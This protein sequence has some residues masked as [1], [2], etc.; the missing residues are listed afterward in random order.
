MAAA[1]GIAPSRDGARRRHRARRRAGDGGD[2]S[3]GGPGVKTPTSFLY[4]QDVATGV[5]TITLNRPDRL[6]ALTFDV[7]DELGTTFRALNIESGVRAIVI[8][9]AGKAFCSGGDVRDIIG[10]LVERDDRGLLE[11]TRMTCDLILAI[12]RC[13]VPVVAALNG[14]T[15][16]AGAVMAT[17]CDVRIAAASARIAFLFTKVG[18]SGADM[19]AAWLLPRIVGRGRAAELLMSGDF[20]SAEEAFRIGLYN[21]VVADG[22]ALAAATTFAEQLARGPSLALE[23]TKDAIDREASLD[24]SSALEAEAR[25]QASLMTQADFREAYAAFV[26]KRPP[27]FV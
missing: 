23:V 26:A 3:D 27:K 18:L 12:R 21:R 16:G 14:T 25:I 20:I 5:A 17:A 7:Y 9:G 10:A 22:A 24:L 2:R 11:F 8:T 13:R 15:A 6:N 4:A 19:G 1:H